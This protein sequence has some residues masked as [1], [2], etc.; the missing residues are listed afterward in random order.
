MLFAGAAN[1]V[2][3]KSEKNEFCD[4]VGEELSAELDKSGLL[5]SL[6]NVDGNG[7]ITVSISYDSGDGEVKQL[8]IGGSDYCGS[9]GETIDLNNN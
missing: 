8:P 4:Q 5:E 9:V 3:Y 6:K 2:I 1:D 7:Q